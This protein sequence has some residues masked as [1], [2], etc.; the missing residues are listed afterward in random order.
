MN[1]SVWI[2][3]NEHTVKRCE[4]L[5]GAMALSAGLA[6]ALAADRLKAEAPPAAAPG[7]GTGKGAMAMTRQIERLRWRSAWVTHLGCIEG[8]LDRLGGRAQSEI[9]SV[10]VSLR[11]RLVPLPRGLDDRLDRGILRLPAQVADDPLA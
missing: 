10:P 3:R 5:R 8:C 2:G 4:F 6:A 11:P 9:R 7:A 1:T